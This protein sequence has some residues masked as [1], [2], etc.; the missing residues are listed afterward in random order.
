MKK[1]AILVISIL[2]FIQMCVP[3]GASDMAAPCT[4]EQVLSDFEI[5][6]NGLARAVYYASGDNTTENITITI[7]L[8]KRTLL[9]F[10]ND[11]ETW[12]ITSNDTSCSGSVEYQLTKSGTYRCT[13]VYEV[14]STDG[15]VE[16]KEYQE[17]IEYDP[18]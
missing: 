14:T 13:I 3:C 4:V 11:V 7:T 9:L 2:M 15:T 5:N 6:T 12:T 17:R 18:A 10:W 8:E 1:V 16:S